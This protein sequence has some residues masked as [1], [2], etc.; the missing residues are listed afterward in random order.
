MRN[1]SIHL[2][3][4]DLLQ[5]LTEIGYTKEDSIE[6]ANDILKVASKY[7][8]KN[9]VFV[10]SGTKVERTKIVRSVVSNGA[11]VELFNRI[12]D[13]VRKQKKHQFVRQI[14]KTDKEYQM[15]KDIAT[16][17]EEYCEMFG[18]S[19][20]ETGFADFCGL[21]V[22]LMG[23]KYGLSKFKY[24][25]G[26]IFDLKESVVAIETDENKKGTEE[27]YQIYK[28]LMVVYA[29][30]EVDLKNPFKPERFKHIIFGRQEADENKADYKTWIKAQ[31]EGLQFL[32]V[33]PELSQ[34]YGDKAKERYDRAYVQENKP[35]VVDDTKIVDYKSD[36]EQKYWEMLRKQN[37]G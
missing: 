30:L 7:A 13:S 15:L 3:K 23:K 4:S 1:P 28:K 31:F 33:V 27:F 29:N 18:Y 17:A 26:H 5:V 16:I 36:G 32:N 21:G 2:K 22:D 35:D 19:N 14:L 10:Y 24:Y 34:F 25:K 37:K 6:L 8:V 11:D 12:L 20:K 9:R